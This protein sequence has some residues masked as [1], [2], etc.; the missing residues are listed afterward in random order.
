LA[1]A[2]ENGGVQRPLS[3]ERKPQADKRQCR[4]LKRQ[5]FTLGSALLVEQRADNKTT[6]RQLGV[7]REA[8]TL[9]GWKPDPHFAGS[10]G[11]SPQ[12]EG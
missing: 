10:G 1:T 2:C 7:L 4:R 6:Q 12:R 3:R 9:N 5:G 8:S 11:A